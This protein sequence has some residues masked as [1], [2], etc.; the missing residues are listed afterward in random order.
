MYKKRTIDSYSKKWKK[1]GSPQ[2]SPKKGKKNRLK[3]IRSENHSTRSR[4]GS[5]MNFMRKAN[6]EYFL[7]SLNKSKPKQSDLIQ[8]TSRTYKRKNEFNKMKARKSVLNNKLMSRN[9]SLENRELKEENEVLKSMQK[10]LMKRLKQQDVYFNECMFMKHKEIES[11][12]KKVSCF[13]IE[14][15]SLVE[16][17]RRTEMKIL[18]YKRDLETLSRFIQNHSLISSS[19]ECDEVEEEVSDMKSISQFLKTISHI[20]SSSEDGETGNERVSVQ[21][22]FKEDSKNSSINL[23]FVLKNIKKESKRCKEKKK[24]RTANFY[25]PISRGRRD[26]NKVSANANFCN[27]F[28]NHFVIKEEESEEERGS[29]D[30]RYNSLIVSQ[31]IPL[32]NTLLKDMETTQEI[33]SVLNSASTRK[34]SIDSKTDLSEISNFKKKAIFGIDKNVIDMLEKIGNS[35]ELEKLGSVV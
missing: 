5:G 26:S 32:N 17:I 7:N 10:I 27:S 33:E 21:R 31:G 23:N 13:K 20:D 8:N 19:I 14:K 15:I 2:R 29:I 4:S 12:K 3:A 24:K 28:D 1:K 25:L 35:Q 16:K 22:Q 9:K 34:K 6:E 30:D 18:R 11:L